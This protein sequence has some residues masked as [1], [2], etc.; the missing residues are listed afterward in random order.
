MVSY[1]ISGAEE[2]DSTA[3]VFIT[4]FLFDSRFFLC[5]CANQIKT[6]QTIKNDHH[7]LTFFPLIMQI[8]FLLQDNAIPIPF[9]S[10]K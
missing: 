8:I 5:V 3:K 7:M 6:I 9:K 10:L 2:N 1:Q 4:Y